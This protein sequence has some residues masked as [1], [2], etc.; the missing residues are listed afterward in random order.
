MKYSLAAL[1]LCTL[2]AAAPAQSQAVK[3]LQDIQLDNGITLADW[4]AL[5]QNKQATPSLAAAT[6]AATFIRRYGPYRELLDIV[7][8]ASKAVELSPG[9]VTIDNAAQKLVLLADARTQLGDW[10]DLLMAQVRGLAMTGQSD[11]ALVTLKRWMAIVPADQPGRP[12]IVALLVEAESNPNALNQ[13]MARTADA[14]RVA[15][16]VRPIPRSLAM[17]SK[18][19]AL[20]AKCLGETRNPVD[21]KTQSLGK[22]S[23]Q[24]TPFEFLMTL[25][26][27][28]PGLRQVTTE[29][30]TLSEYRE[31]QQDRVNSPMGMAWAFTLM[32]GSGPLAGRTQE[33]MSHTTAIECD[34]PLLPLA[35]G[36]VVRTSYSI[37]TSIQWKN[38]PTP[39]ASTSTYSSR[40]E[41]K[42]VA[43]P[44]RVDEAASKYPHIRL[45]GP[46]ASQWKVYELQFTTNLRW[47]D[48]Q[49]P[50][51]TTSAN[52]LFVE[53]PNVFVNLENK[54]LAPGWTW[55]LTELPRQ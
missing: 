5:P 18:D 55:T 34:E 20:A 46:S 4:A 30:P 39:E 47:S 10:P 24:D 12:E 45:V 3:R 25:Q 14:V 27:L 22:L 40:S 38:A 50:P 16:P 49:L 29:V 41:Y 21:V 52:L 6:Q 33:V 9:E 28:A 17:Y 1:S 42:T 15:A 23:G 36:K 44:W 43:G 53:G 2:L 37:T 13:W 51:N 7:W 54:A 48:N 8:R 11:A 19:I 31:T 26:A 35:V 32:P